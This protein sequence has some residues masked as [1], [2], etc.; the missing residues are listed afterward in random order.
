MSDGIT[1]G[2]RMTREAEK[3]LEA[4]GWVCHPVGLMGALWE[5]PLEPGVKY[6]RGQA[7]E[8]QEAREKGV[9]DVMDS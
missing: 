2:Y 8:I 9:S 7:E 3:A 6:L 4:K 5:D 1:D